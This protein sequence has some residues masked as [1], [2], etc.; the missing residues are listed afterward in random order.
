MEARLWGDDLEKIFPIIN[1]DTSDSGQID[2]ALE[3]LVLSGR[4][5]PH[6]M[7]MLIPEAWDRDPSCP[8]TRGRSTA[9]PVLDGAVGRARV[10]RVHGWSSRGRRARSN[11]LRPSRYWMTK[12]NFAVLASETGVLP[13]DPEMVTSKDGCSPAVCS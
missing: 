13:I 4:S 9:T 3:F 8:P 2:N 12:D 1:P 10:D 11:G 5:L 7:M 6:A